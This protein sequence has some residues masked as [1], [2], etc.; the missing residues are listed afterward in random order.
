MAVRAKSKNPQVGQAT[1]K[2]FEL[3]SGSKFL[4]LTDLHVNELRIKVM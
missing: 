2:S 3:I 4:S 1:A